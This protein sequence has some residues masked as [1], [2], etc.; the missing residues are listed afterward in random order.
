MSAAIFQH[1]LKEF[2]VKTCGK[3]TTYLV[4]LT[5]LRGLEASKWSRQRP[6]DD[7]RVEEIRAGIES[8]GDVTGVLCMA[9][10]PTEKMIVYDGQHRWKALLSIDRSDLRVFVE[11]LWDA[12]EEEIIAAF[13]TV[14]ACVP[15]SELYFAPDARDVRPDIH[16]L[17]T[18]I[19]QK[20]PDFVS[21]AAKPNRP[22][23]NRDALAQEIYELW[24]DTFAKEQTVASIEKGLVTLNRTYHE[25]L[26]SY[27]RLA[28]R[29]HPRIAEKCEKHRFWLF[30]ESGHINRK[31]LAELLLN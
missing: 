25:D 6:A 21:T 12:A 30:A 26:G 3:R 14:N 8:T 31:H 23:F 24:S 1:Y 5:H 4:P 20:F 16:E 19:C 27:P 22:Q 2:T 18:R 17:I 13:K 9:W 28:S 29:K 10:H 11:V 7:A 15:V